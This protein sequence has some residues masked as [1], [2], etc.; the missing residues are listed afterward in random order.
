MVFFDYGRSFQCGMASTMAGDVPYSHVIQAF[1][2][3]DVT[4]LSEVFVRLHGI[5]PDFSCSSIRTCF[6]CFTSNKNQALTFSTHMRGCGLHK[7]ASLAAL[8]SA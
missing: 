2:T 3:K 1:I 5:I 8:P 6:L 7:Q 4:T